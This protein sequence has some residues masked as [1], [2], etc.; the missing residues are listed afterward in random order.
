M[1]ALALQSVS[2]ARLAV[3]GQFTKGIT[4]PAEKPQS[5][6]THLF[7][8]ASFIAWLDS[9]TGLHQASLLMDVESLSARLRFDGSGN[10]ILAGSFF[11]TLKLASTTDELPNAPIAAEAS[12]ILPEEDILLMKRLDPS[13]SN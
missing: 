1:G 7:P 2:S 3:F 9:K 13:T 11:R 5:A 10:L 8:K 4:F 6:R 12:G